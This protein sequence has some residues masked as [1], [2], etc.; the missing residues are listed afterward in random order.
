MTQKIGGLTMKKIIVLIL[1]A[2]L[3]MNASLNV[4]HADGM[5]LPDILSPNYLA[6]RY[7]RV[8]VAIEDNHAVTRVEQEFYNPNE[9]PVTGRY[10]FPVPPGAMLTGFTAQLDGQ[11]QPLFRQDAAATNND[12]YNMMLQRR[13]P[14]LLQY[15]DWE[16][17]AFDLALEAG[18]SRPMTLEYEEV[19]APVGGLLHYRYILSTERYSGLPLEDVS[20]TVDL[21]LDAGI[22][23]LYSSS[24]PIETARNGQKD[25]RVVWQESGARPET[26]FDLYYS[27]SEDGFGAG[28]LTSRTGDQNHLLFLFAP[29]LEMES[30]RVI[31]KDIL[32]VVDCSG[33]MA[34][35]KIDQAHKA[36]NFILGQLNENDRFSIIGFD[37]QLSFF[38]YS[39]EPVDDAAVANASQFV[40][41]LNAEGW[42]NI[43]GA[44]QAGMQILT[45]DP[46]QNASS[47]LL[48]LTDG[49]PTAGITDEPVIA[50]RALRANPDRQVRAHVFGV[51]Y[52]VN[53]HLLDR[54]AAQN[55]GTV[56][57][58]QPG[59]DLESVLT[60]FYA[61]I[62]D[63]VLTGIEIEFD[64]LE[65][66]DFYPEQIPDM[67]R[68]S[69]LILAGRF[70]DPQDVV[71]VT[72]RGQ[73]AAGAKEYT[74]TFF[75]DQIGD[76]PFVS[77]LWATRRVGKL[78][79]VI[80]V[81][82]ETEKLVGEVR[83]LGLTYGLITPYTTFIIEAQ[84][85]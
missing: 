76:Q 66:S 37:D 39:L 56:T 20:V 11:P 64:G 77:R 40:D 29:D 53:T 12:L 71:R 46:R 54:L 33:S 57:Y 60:E 35:E 38:S 52:D 50:E 85:N 79:D 32:F 2:I 82:G 25:A 26:D 43:D 30:Q 4:A 80:R 23:A 72:I 5:I 61:N 42:T 73:T 58:V 18:E 22:G 51:G 6:V 13:D 78:L 67:F 24:H 19:L 84:A 21:H 34:G 8:S 49:L 41:A 45:A 70:S 83:D 36:L 3:C 31:P 63:P 62:A 7:H 48:F 14:T 44:L 59:Q 17:L 69:S 16:S 55:G 10:L 81:E 75:I 65:A 47:M 27:S 15:A 68:G 1:A 28:L 74:Y 9:F